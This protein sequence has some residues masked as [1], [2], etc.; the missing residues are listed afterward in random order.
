MRW[1]DGITNSM[2]T[3]LN[4]LRETVKDREAWRAAVHRITKSQTR[5]SN[6]TTTVTH[7]LSSHHLFTHSLTQQMFITVTCAGHQAGCCG[8]Y[9]IRL[10]LQTGEEWRTGVT[11]GRQLHA[12]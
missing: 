4:K 9:K 7:S 12:R 1:L 2:D 6:W 3:N 11:L 5:L 10:D 8:R